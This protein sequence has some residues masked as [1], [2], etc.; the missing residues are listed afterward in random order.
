EAAAEVHSPLGDRRRRRDRAVGREAEEALAGRGVEGLQHVVDAD[1]A[2]AVRDRDRRPDPGIERAL[3][4]RGTVARIE[5]REQ[6][7]RLAWI[8]DANRRA[9]AAVAAADAGDENV[10]PVE[11]AVVQHAADQ[12]AAGAHR[13]RPD[14]G[15]VVAIE[16]P[17][18]AR[19]LPAAD[20]LA[21]PAF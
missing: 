9:S 8:A 19:L 15:A 13:A 4:H 11:G 7:R 2:D 16:R 21:L 17:E 18:D 6:R 3:P 5:R 12:R 1:V 10:M 14:D 20:Q